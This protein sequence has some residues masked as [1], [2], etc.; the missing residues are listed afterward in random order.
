MIDDH[1]QVPSPGTTTEWSLGA[2]ETVYDPGD[3]FI[4]VLRGPMTAP[5]G[6]TWSMH[7]VETSPGTQGAVCVAL[8]SDRLLLAEHWRATTGTWGLEFPR[9][10]GSP[11]EEGVDTARREL[12]EETGLTARTAVQLGTIHA[13]TGILRDRIAVVEM[14]VE[15]HAGEQTDGELGAMAWLSPERIDALIAAGE[16][17]DGITLAAYAVW[18]AHQ[19]H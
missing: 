7:I 5:D 15:A 17:T 18:R 8:A 10:M 19:G 1:P 9:G 11:D 3:G 4:R 12:L 14:T 2:L 16:L 13:D 6:R